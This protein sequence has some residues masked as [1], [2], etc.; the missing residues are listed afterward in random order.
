MVIVLIINIQEDE[1]RSKNFI[2]SLKPTQIIAIGFFLI[3]LAGAILL[4]LPI[5]SKSGNP[6]PFVDAL[7]TATSATC[8]TGLV[9]Y[10]TA[11][12]WTLFGQLV[13]IALIQTGGLGFMTMATLMS[14]LIRR[15]ISLRERL[16]M[17]ESLNHEHVQGI[18]GT[19]KR[20]L[21]VTCAIELIGGLLLSIRFFPR[22][23]P[24]GIY[25]GIW[26]SISAFCNAGFDLLGTPGR[27]FISITEY[28]H[29]PIVNFTIMSLI[30]IGG[31]GFMV[32]SNLY[33]ARRISDL[34]VHTKLVLIITAIL[35]FGGAALY[36]FFE[37]NNSN[38]IQSFNLPEKIL[39]SLFQSVTPR[40]AGF[41]TID[42]DGMTEMSKFITIFLMFIGGSPGSTAG[43]VKTVTVGVFILAV[44]S[45]IRGKKDTEVFY[46]RIPNEV[47]MRSIAIIAISFSAALIV[48][49]ILMIFERQPL[50]NCMFETMSAF[51]TVGL[52]ANLTPKLH[53][54]SKLALSALMYTGRVGGLTL[55]MAMSL[56]HNEDKGK[57]RYPEAKIMIG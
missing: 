2:Y 43:G 13:I 4:T 17:V 34:M 54:I 9:V 44:I 36:L 12:H 14:F 47:V 18:V 27:Q 51:G 52:S 35:I 8:I 29:D 50:I 15:K 5:A 56:R 28:V 26:M 25:M 7:F 22:F 49:N 23:G 24:R 41:N 3:I 20:V 16:L 55:F 6:T 21:L 53:T 42:Q 31:L 45:V 40:T 57:I 10:D 19:V 38:T 37:Y 33:N 30:V 32:W 48:F 46:N 11:T 39:A 1:N